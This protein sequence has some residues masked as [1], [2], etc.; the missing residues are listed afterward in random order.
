MRTFAGA[1]LFASALGPAACGS[2]TGAERPGVSLADVAGPEWT[3]VELDGAPLPAGAD[4][5]TALFE[6]GAVAGFSGCNRY[7]GPVREVSPGVVEIGPV[8]GTMMM[9]EPPEMELEGKF[10]AALG[11]VTRY[12]LATGRLAL[13]GDGSPPSGR[14]VF[15]RR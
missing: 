1:W 12:A 14:L 3:L 2:P 11:K 5:P 7:R 10:L 15:E 4:A 13:E 9:C 8:A 6:A